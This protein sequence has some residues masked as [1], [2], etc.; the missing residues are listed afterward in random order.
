[1]TDR[2]EEFKEWVDVKYAHTEGVPV[3]KLLIKQFEEEQAKKET[4]KEIKDIISKTMIGLSYD[5][6]TILCQDAISQTYKKLKE[7]ELIK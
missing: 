4:E 3:V 7:N 1:M 6:V 2:Y 5:E